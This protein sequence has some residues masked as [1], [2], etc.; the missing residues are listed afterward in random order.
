MQSATLI[1]KKYLNEQVI[2]LKLRTQKILTQPGQWFFI[3]YLD[4]ETPLKRAYSI[5][6]V[7]QEGEFSIFT[8]LIKLVPGGKGSELLKKA[9]EDS[10]FWLEGPNG[11]FILRNTENPKVFLATGSGLAPCYRMA[12][13]ERFWAKKWFFFSVSYEKDLFYTQEIKALW[14]PET[15]I[16]ISREK[17]DGF[18]FWRIDIEKFNFPKDTEFYIC[19]VP[20]MVKEFLAKLRGERYTQIF[21]ES[22]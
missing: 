21:V 15:H 20:A 4:S 1:Q 8:F 13:A 18:E 7:E 2:E 9:D 5:A 12:K 14:I 3:H 19:W 16:S 11:Y 10:S 22:Y 17:V 6:D